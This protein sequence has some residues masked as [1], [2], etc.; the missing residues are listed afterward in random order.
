MFGRCWIFWYFCYWVSCRAKS[1]SLKY[2]KI[3]FLISINLIYFFGIEMTY[4]FSFLSSFPSFPFSMSRHGQFLCRFRI[5]VNHVYPRKLRPKC[6]SPLSMWMIVRPFS[7]SPNTM[8]HYYCQ[9]IKMWPSFKWMQQ[10]AT[11]MVHRPAAMAAHYA[12]KLS[13]IPIRTAYSKWTAT[14]A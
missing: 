9:P 11:K 4:F 3:S 5:W 10:I 8:P 14:L 7:L 2:I 1:F 6:K 12:T 13:K